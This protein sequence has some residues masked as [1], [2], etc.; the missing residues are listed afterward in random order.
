MPEINSTTYRFSPLKKN[1]PS[2]RHSFSEG[3]K[4]P[5]QDKL[6]K[7]ENS[8]SNLNRSKAISNLTSLEG[9]GITDNIVEIQYKYS[10][11]EQI[12][13]KNY[14]YCGSATMLPIN[15]I[16]MSIDK[17]GDLILIKG[18][19]YDLLKVCSKNTLPVISIK[20]HD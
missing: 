20:H 9:V 4:L 13:A 12:D 14:V 6:I 17:N 8:P 1:E 16:G 7:I 11:P 2:R 3:C 5:F 18:D 15:N 10:Q 19:S